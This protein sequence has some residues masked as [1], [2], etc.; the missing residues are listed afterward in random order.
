M[1]PKVEQRSAPRITR[2]VLGKVRSPRGELNAE[3]RD[4]SQRGAFFFTPSRLEE[5]SHIELILI[6]PPEIT[7]LG[8]QWVCCQGTVLRVEEPDHAGQFG[9]AARLDRVEALPQI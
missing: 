8:T 1:R 2:R 6:M 5:G 3:T 7:H 4:I 9:V